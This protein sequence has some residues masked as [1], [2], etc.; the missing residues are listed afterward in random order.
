MRNPG[1]GYW[2]L[3]GMSVLSG[4]EPE[5]W[6]TV[7]DRGRQSCTSLHGETVPKLCSK[8]EWL[9]R[10]GQGSQTCVPHSPSFHCIFSMTLSG[11]WF[12]KEDTSFQVQVGQAGLFYLSSFA[13]SVEAVYLHGGA[14]GQHM[15]GRH[16][17]K[18]LASRDLCKS[19]ESAVLRYWDLGLRYNHHLH[20]W[21]IA[22]C[23]IKALHFLFM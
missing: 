9:G 5:A 22:M 3:M 17:V 6:L 16:S 11:Q 7:L 1:L 12:W 4:M 20:S 10:G 18:T 13:E 2:S 8:E 19:E 21:I 23:I 14:L 15:K